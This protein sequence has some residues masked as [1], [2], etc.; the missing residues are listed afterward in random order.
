[1]DKQI[2]NKK[3]DE[4]GVNVVFLDDDVLKKIDKKIINIDELYRLFNPEGNSTGTYI[5]YGGYGGGYGGGGYSGGGWG[6]FGGGSF[7]GGGSGGSW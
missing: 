4:L 6:G 3:L 2:L 5:S 1:M 7:G